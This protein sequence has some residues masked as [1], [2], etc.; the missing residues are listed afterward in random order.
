MKIP[1]LINEDITEEVRRDALQETSEYHPVQE[2]TILQQLYFGSKT[3]SEI[4]ERTGIRL[5]SVRRGLSNLKADGR[6]LPEGKQMNPDGTAP[7]T[8]WK[9]NRNYKKPV[10]IGNETIQQ[11]NFF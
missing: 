10:K 9:I 7:E 3:A 11:Q 5:T 8:V 4:E 2:E 1:R 6:I